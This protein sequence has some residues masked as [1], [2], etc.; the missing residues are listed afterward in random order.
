VT[1]QAVEVAYL[2][3]VV[4]GTKSL[5][6]QTKN[7]KPQGQYSLED[8]LFPTTPTKI[9]EACKG[10][11]DL[12]AEGKTATEMLSKD[13]CQTQQTKTSKQL[14]HVYSKN[15]TKSMSSS[16]IKYN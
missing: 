6:K 4:H 15:L 16:N 8:V 3:G 1:S 9:Y 14:L 7:S 13:S 10:K 2:N 11:N 12:Y 5:N